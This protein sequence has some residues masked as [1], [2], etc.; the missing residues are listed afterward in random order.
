MIRKIF[1][2]FSNELVAN[3]A[4]LGW[5]GNNGLLITPGVCSRVFWGMVLTD[6]PLKVTD[7]HME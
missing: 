5:I 6:A 1:G 2:A 4:G 3:M 7:T